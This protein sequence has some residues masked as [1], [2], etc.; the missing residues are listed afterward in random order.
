MKAQTNKASILIVDDTPDNLRLLSQV[1]KQNGYKVRAVS[2]GEQALVAADVAPPDLILLD[3]MMAGIDGYEVCKHLKAQSRTK[4]IPVIF[5]S[6][7][8]Q[9]LNRVKA[10]AVG[11]VDY[12]TKPF[13]YDEV[14]ARVRS[15][16]GLHLLH[17]AL[18]DE[19]AQREQDQAMLR[20]YANELETQNAELNAFAHTVAHDLKNPLGL[21]MGYSS[22]LKTPTTLAEDTL[23]TIAQSITKNVS[24]MNNIIDELLLLSSVRN[25][26]HIELSPLDMSRLIQDARNRI[27]DLIETHQAEIIVPDTW[28]LALGHGPWIEEVWVNYLSNAIKY[29]GRPPRVELGYDGVPETQTTEQ[30]TIRFWVRDNGMGLSVAQQ[31][32]LFT[33][34]ERLH[35]VRVEGHG[36]GL[37]IVKRIVEKLGG[38]VG[39]ESQGIPGQGS[40]FYF[41]LPKAETDLA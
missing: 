30:P 12:V 40:I 21:L 22:L 25:I 18:R 28:P 10:F 33:P 23:T 17:Q 7:M 15:H 39:V 37:S 11:G 31:A 5:I 24:K 4:E 13:Q 32:Q 26:E 3:I 20:R 8:D 38:E 14:L 1:L 16:V 2:S 9:P 19:I 29:G 35:Q 41:I 6:A 27:E 34:F 36:L